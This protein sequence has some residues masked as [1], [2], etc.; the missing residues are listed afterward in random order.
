MTIVLLLMR[1][2]LL[3]ICIFTVICSIFEKYLRSR[4]MRLTLDSHIYRRKVFGIEGR[5]IILDKTS[6]FFNPLDPVSN[7]IGLISDDLN[8]KDYVIPAYKETVEL[9]RNHKLV[10]TWRLDKVE[11]LKKEAI[12]RKLTLKL[13]QEGR[14]S[15]FNLN[16]IKTSSIQGISINDAMKFKPRKKLPIK[17]VFT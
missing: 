11:S 9:L 13:Y 5:N 16:A 7:L 8:S 1:C 10:K 15:Y 12:M 6:Q 14:A 3:T 17:R 2:D 4:L